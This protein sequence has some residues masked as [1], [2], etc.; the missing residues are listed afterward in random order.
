MKNNEPEI[1]VGIDIGSL[2]ICS[3]V[4]INSFVKNCSK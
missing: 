4:Y 1:G 2:N 3:G